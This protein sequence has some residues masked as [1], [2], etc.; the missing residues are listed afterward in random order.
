M[1]C[2]NQQ[3]K[4][5]IIYLPAKKID[6]LIMQK[7]GAT[8]GFDANSV[9]HPTDEVYHVGGSGE[10]NAKWIVTK[11]DIKEGIVAMMS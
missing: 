10:G 1:L 4:I 7:N 9:F 6:G 2:N 3:H 11:L 5:T 8:H